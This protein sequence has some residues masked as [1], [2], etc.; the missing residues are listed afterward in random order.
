M[1]NNIKKI[2]LVESQCTGC[3]ACMNVCPKK[4]IKMK[5]REGYFMFPEVDDEACINCGLCKDV[6]PALKKISE[7]ENKEYPKAFGCYV[8]NQDTRLKS[9][10]GGAFSVLA[11]YILAKKGYVCA[12]AISS[13]VDLKHEI[14]SEIKDLEK[15]HGSK[16]F[17]SNVGFAY[18]RVKKLLQNGE[19]VLFVGT[20]CQVAGLKA[21]LGQ[22]YDNLITVDLFCHGVP[23]QKLFEQYVNELTNGKAN[24]VRNLQ[25]R[26]KLVDGW[27]NFH[28]SFD[29]EE[30]HYDVP[31]KNDVYFKAFRDCLTLRKS[32][33]NCKFAA[34]PRQGDFTIGDFLALARKELNIVDDKGVSTLLVNN[35]KAAKILEEVKDKFEILS[36]VALNKISMV[37]LLNSHSYAH[38]NAERFREALFRKEDNVKNLMNEYLSKSDNIAIMNWHNSHNNYGSV[39]TGYALKE[40]IKQKIGFSPVHII[41]YVKGGAPDISDLIDFVQEHIPETPPCWNDKYRQGLNKYCQTFIAGPDGV[42]RNMSFAPNFFMYLLDF[43]DTSKNICSYAPSFGLNRIVNTK[44][45]GEESIP[46]ARDIL[47]R[48]SLLKRFNHISVREDSGV[49]LCKDVFD[50]EAEHVLDAVFLL[51]EQDYQKLI[52]T[53]DLELP[54]E[55]VAKYILNQTCVDSSIIKFIDENENTVPLYIGKDHIDFIKKKDNSGWAYSGPKLVDWLKLLQGAKYIVTDSYHGLCFAIIFKKQFVLTDVT[56]A[57]TERHRSLLRMLD[58]SEDRFASSLEDFQRILNTPIDYDRVYQKLDFWRK[59]SDQFLDKI[60]EDNKPNKIRDWVESAE[61]KD[62]LLRTAPKPVVQKK[63]SIKLRLL[64]ISLFKKKITAQGTVIKIL[65]IPLIKI[66]TS[67]NNYRKVYF[68]GV[69][70][71]YLHRLG[72][73]EISISLFKRIKLFSMKKQAV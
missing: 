59:K 21:V 66:K 54:K 15:F 58:I 41:D 9:T 16:Y 67:K 33:T 51:Q 31:A 63:Y 26:N 69:P 10:S 55:Y 73:D 7:H 8:S 25:F 56:F 20:P 62:Y 37:N 70:L 40:R 13:G 19:N 45:G 49:K 27:E 68:M 28:F 48:K 38:I 57:G 39:L 72:N 32:C 6:C 11:E 17:Q 60:L 30:G 12:A 43:A 23:P 44:I 2:S 46:T 71:L 65:G 64:G 47:K 34:L 24:T 1:F 61:I 22:P 4:A 52:D 29:Y 14:V 18:N 35:E 3:G 50:V 42:W 36:S 5:A 53:S